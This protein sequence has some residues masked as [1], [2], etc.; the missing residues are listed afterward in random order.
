MTTPLSVWNVAYFFSVAKKC[1]LTCLVFGSIDTGS[2][3]CV[4]HSVSRQVIVVV[5]P[6]EFLARDDEKR[7]R[8]ENVG[9]IHDL[10]VAKEGELECWQVSSIVGLNVNTEKKIFMLAVFLWLWPSPFLFLQ[11]EKSRKHNIRALHIEWYWL[12]V[13]HAICVRRIVKDSM[14][15]GGTGGRSGL[16]HSD[17]IIE[18]MILYSED[19]WGMVAN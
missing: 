1:G 10:V 18:L 15:K 2:V 3:A 4:Y 14:M 12:R 17:N 7:L 8:R 13:L 9:I 11:D 19:H 6:I 16:C 5:I